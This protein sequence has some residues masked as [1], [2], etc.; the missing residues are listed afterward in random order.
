MTLAEDKYKQLL[1]ISNPDEANKNAK[2]YYKNDI[3][4]STRKNKKYMILNPKNNKWIH[5][6]SFSPPMEDFLYHKN[7]E[8]RRKYLKRAMNIKGDWKNNEY[9]PN[10]LSIIILWN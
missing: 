4:I 7:E 3:Y 2:K 6:G 8:R 1:K 9:S 10:M 5:F